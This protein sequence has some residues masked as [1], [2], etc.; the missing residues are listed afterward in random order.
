MADPLARD[1]G[2]SPNAPW[3]GI[4]RIRKPACACPWAICALTS[5]N[6]PLSCSEV[7]RS[8]EKWGMDE[9]PHPRLPRRPAPRAQDAQTPSGV[10]RKCSPASTGTRWTAR[11]G[12]PSPPNSAPSC[13][14]VR[15]SRAGWM[16]AWRST[17]RTAGIACPRR[18][19]RC[20]SPN[21]TARRFQRY[22]FAGAVEAE[23][24]GQGR[25][26]LPAYLREAVGLTTEAVIVG[27]R[28]HAEI[29]SPARWTDYSRELDEPQA[30]A[31]AFEGLGI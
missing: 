6:Q 16:T 17:R 2:P 20:P 24:D 28:D 23:L 27:S 3:V 19:R 10:A 5:W 14:R 7:A 31:D 8:G 12:W 9:T 25:V 22:V 30:L 1:A 29:W 26:L 4:R 18:S 21:P 15:W 11:D 13:S